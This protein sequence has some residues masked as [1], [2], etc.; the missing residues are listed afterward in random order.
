MERGLYIALFKFT[1]LNST[2][3]YKVFYAVG[4][5]D[6]RHHLFHLSSRHPARHDG[7]A[8]GRRQPRKLVAHLPPI[9]KKGPVLCPLFNIVSVQALC[10][11]LSPHLDTEEVVNPPCQVPAHPDGWAPA[12]APKPELEGP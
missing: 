3:L 6:H 9:Q 10:G 7:R 12:E 4:D 2:S 11:P 8:E 1:E 5:V